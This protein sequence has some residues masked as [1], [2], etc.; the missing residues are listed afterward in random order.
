MCVCGRIYVCLR[1][2]AHVLLFANDAKWFLPISSRADCLSLQH[3]LSLIANWSSSWNLT[4]N[5]NKCSV[6]HFIIGQSSAILS[7][8]VKGAR[9]EC[10][11]ILT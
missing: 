8:S 2:F 9:S 7:Y 4:F 10:F 5:E 1:M 6:V 11:R 3:D